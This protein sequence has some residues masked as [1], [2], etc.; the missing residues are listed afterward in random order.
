MSLKSVCL[1]TSDGISS[2]QTAPRSN[3]GHHTRR[4]RTPGW[5]RLTPVALAIISHGYQRV[6]VEMML[7]YI[8][9]W[10]PFADAKALHKACAKT[11]S[12]PQA[13]EAEIASAH[14][15]CTCMRS[16]EHAEQEHAP[17]STRRGRHHVHSPVEASRIPLPPAT[18]ASASCAPRRPPPG[19]PP[20]GDRR[21]AARLQVR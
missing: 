11:C 17:F 3:A 14:W 21:R 10:A 1:A 6:H 7:W 12:G 13:L 4:S 2:R 20:A 8:N 18:P 9:R 15:L 5:P 16:C 19:P